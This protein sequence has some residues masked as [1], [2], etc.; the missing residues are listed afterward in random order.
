MRS[1]FGDLFLFLAQLKN[2]ISKK[3]EAFIREIKKK[4]KIKNK[5][6][7]STIKNLS[8]QKK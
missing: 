1:H 6:Q 8:K 5:E 4:Q 2:A 7:K 3:I